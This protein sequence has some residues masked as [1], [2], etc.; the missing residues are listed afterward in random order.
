VRTDAGREYRA[1]RVVIAGLPPA[2]AGRM[3]T[4]AGGGLPQIDGDE[5]TAACLD[6]VLHRLIRGRPSFA[7]GLD[8]PLY[9]SAHSPHAQ[10]APD[11]GAVVHL[12]RY[13]DG[14]AGSDSETRQRL[15]ELMDL[16]QPGWRDQL[17]DARFAPR[18]TVTSLLPRPGA[19]LASRPAV[20]DTGL[21]GVLIAGDWVGPTGWL[22]GGSVASGAAAAETIIASRRSAP[23]RVATGGA[24]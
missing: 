21:N 6:L 9:L 16:A 18:M 22:V 23:L 24:V 7:L 12:M 1:G 20:T 3:L 13:G 4:G 14:Q 8:E 11:G 17:I 5:V 15:E 10:L 19:G 2:R